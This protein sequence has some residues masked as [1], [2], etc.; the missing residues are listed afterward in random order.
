M[1][2][3]DFEQ[4]TSWHDHCQG[5]I[6]KIGKKVDEIL[7]SFDLLTKSS[8]FDPDKIKHYDINIQEELDEL[9]KVQ[10]SELLFECKNLKKIEKNQIFP[11]FEHFFGVLDLY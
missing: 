3:F 10:N 9:Y 11:N 8:I 6:E 7:E 2:Y 1:D 5:T 4:L